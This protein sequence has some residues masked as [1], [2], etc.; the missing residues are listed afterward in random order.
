MTKANVVMDCFMEKLGNNEFEKENQPELSQ[1]PVYFQED[2][3]PTPD[4]M[5]YYK[6]RKLSVRVLE[7]NIKSGYLI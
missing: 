6:Y 3:K 2:L 4:N 1:L 5:G 7:R